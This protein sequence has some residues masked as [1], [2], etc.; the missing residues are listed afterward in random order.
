MRS[1]IAAQSPEQLD[2]ATGQQT[3]RHMPYAILTIGCGCGKVRRGND[4]RLAVLRC[5]CDYGAEAGR[6]TVKPARSGIQRQSQSDSA[7]IP[8]RHKR[9]L[10]HWLFRMHGVRPSGATVLLLYCYCAAYQHLAS[11]E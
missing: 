8:S 5:D 11:G 10:C 1:E 4:V 9:R 7:Q 3:H 6:S 2:A